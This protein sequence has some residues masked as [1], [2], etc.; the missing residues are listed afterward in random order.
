MPEIPFVDLKRV[1]APLIDKF[2]NALSEVLDSSSFVLGEPVSCFEENF[3]KYTGAKYTIGAASGADAL[4]LSLK[5]LDIREGDEVLIPANSFSATSDA[6]RRTGAKPVF[7]DV[8]WNSQNLNTSNLDIAYSPRVKAI[9]PVNLYGR[10]ADIGRIQEFC[11]KKGLKMVIDAAQS[12]GAKYHG[13]KLGKFG[14]C[15]CYSF[16]PGKNLGA[17]GE[18]GLVST[19]DQDVAEKIRILR[20]CGQAKKYEHVEVGYNS[21]LHSLQAKFLDIKLEYLDSWNKQRQEA[22]K[23]YMEGIP[24][25]YLPCG[26]SWKD[27]VFHLFVIRHHDRSSLK[28]YLSRSG[29]ET[30]IHYPVPLHLNPS[31]RD[32]G[33]QIGDFPITEK[34]SKVILSI[35]MFVGLTS[36]EIEYVADRIKDFCAI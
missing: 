16:Y 22:A 28:K 1:H 34:L 3:A 4:F 9:I 30:G 11:E 23:H 10:P 19:N 25:E 36:D 14:E 2:H 35:P 29:I 12:H 8:N 21:R 18:G 27:S 15:V 13:E 33:Y 26:I 24:E 32:L 17:L 5:S 6:V 7:I 31:N 20:N